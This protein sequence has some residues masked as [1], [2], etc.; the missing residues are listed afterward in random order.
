MKSRARPQLADPDD[1]CFRGLPRG[2]G[3]RRFLVWSPTAEAALR[4]ERYLAGRGYGF[5]RVGSARAAHG[6]NGN[7]WVFTW[8]IADGPVPVWAGR[9]T[10]FTAESPGACGPVGAVR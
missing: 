4:A 6:P 10:D 9:L 3:I 2:H 1:P 5:H 8:R 7:L